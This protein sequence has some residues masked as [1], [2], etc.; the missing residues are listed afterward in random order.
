M[1]QWQIGPQMARKGWQN[2]RQL[3]LGAGITYP[4][5]WQIMLG[6]PVGRIDTTTL[7]RLAAAFACSPWDLLEHVPE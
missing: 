2:A 7:E 5:A 3:S 1:I 6:G 4:V